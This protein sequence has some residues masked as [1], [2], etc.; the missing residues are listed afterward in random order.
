MKDPRLPLVLRSTEKYGIPI[1]TFAQNIVTEALANKDSFIY[2]ETAGGYESGLLGYHQP[3]CEAMFSSY[4]MVEDIGTLL[5]PDFSNR[6][7]WDAD[8]R[9]AYCRIV[10]LT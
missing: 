3:V 8:Q 5:D 1:Q 9:E 4:E 6:S 10:L 2:R 7:K